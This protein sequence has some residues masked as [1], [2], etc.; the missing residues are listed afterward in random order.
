LFNTILKENFCV[1]NILFAHCTRAFK[2]IITG[3]AAIDNV[4]LDLASKTNTKG[5]FIKINL[6]YI[7]GAIAN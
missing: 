1:V 7:P 5:A 6:S 4:A 2:H 3:I